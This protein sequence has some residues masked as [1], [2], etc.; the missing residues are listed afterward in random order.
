M[1]AQTSGTDLIEYYN[2]TR[3]KRKREL[4]KSKYRTWFLKTRFLADQYAKNIINCEK[5]YLISAIYSNTV[6]KSTKP[7]IDGIIY[8]SVRYIFKG[9][10]MHLHLDYLKIL[11]L[12][13][14]KYHL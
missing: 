8:P 7:L 10:I 5:D 12:K 14:A 2:A 11:V 6:L 13:F 1:I 4:S 3:S 9:F